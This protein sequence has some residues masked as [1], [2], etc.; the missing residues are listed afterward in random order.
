MSPFKE[1]NLRG[2][3]AQKDPGVPAGPLISSMI[4]EEAFSSLP[5]G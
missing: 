4:L 2:R 3:R 5:E 1:S